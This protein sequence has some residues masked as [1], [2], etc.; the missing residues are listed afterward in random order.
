MQDNLR[1]CLAFTGGKVRVNLV[2]F[3]LA[4]VLHV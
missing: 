2:A 4:L 3:H 1:V